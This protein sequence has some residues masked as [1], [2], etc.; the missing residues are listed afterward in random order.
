[1]NGDQFNPVALVLGQLNKRLAAIPFKPFHIVMSN[2]A[3]YMVPTPDHITI[4]RLL[5][6][7]EV[8]TDAL[9]MAEINPLHVATIEVHQ[10]AA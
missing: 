8:E 10:D 5:R 2:G 1:M 6:R 4:T 7:I 3:R 9:H